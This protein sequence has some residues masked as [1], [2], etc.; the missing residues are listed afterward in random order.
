MF[1]KI[2]LYGVL[3]LV[4]TLSSVFY[5]RYVPTVVGNLCGPNGNEFCYEPLPRAGFPF[6]YWID[7]GGISVEGELGIDDD[8]SVLAF[9]GDL[10]FFALV[11][12]I[13]ERLIR[14]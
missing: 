12:F 1:K 5:I 6:S 3:P 10:L 8:I 9:G 14:K 4:L 11:G 7:V 13:I 2:F